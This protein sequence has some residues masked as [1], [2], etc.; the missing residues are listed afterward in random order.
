MRCMWA[1]I[2]GDGKAHELVTGKRVYA[3][4]IEP[5]ATDGSVIAWYAFDPAAKEWIRHVIFQGEPAKNAPAKGG[6]R[7]ALKDFP[8]GTAGTG[9]QMTAIDIDGTAT[10]TSSAPARAGS[11]SSRTC[12]CRSERSRRRDRLIRPS[13]SGGSSLI[14]ASWRVLWSSPVI[15][16]DS[17]SDD[18]CGKRGRFPHFSRWEHNNEVNE[19]YSGFALWANSSRSER[20]APRS[21]FIT[22]DT[23]G[24]TWTGHLSIGQHCYFW[25]S[26][27]CDDAFLVDTGACTKPWR[28]RS[29]ASSGGWPICSGMLLGS[30]A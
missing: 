7:L 19:S 4:E 20:P 15:L 30:V 29:R 25:S 2:D 10:S 16:S 9:L 1:D 27:D 24:T 6:D 18:P 17:R 21:F 28:T 22:F 14:V 13:H 11:I 8:P 26:A 3:H 12:G 23:H 5:G